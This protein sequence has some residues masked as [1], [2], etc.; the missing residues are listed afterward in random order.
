MATNSRPLEPTLR[1]LLH[2]ARTCAAAD[3]IIINKLPLRARLRGANWA[4]AEEAAWQPLSLT[5]TAHVDTAPAGATDALDYSLN[6]MDLAGAAEEVVGQDD[7]A[8]LAEIAEG[9]SEGAL[10]VTRTAMVRPE[11]VTVDLRQQAGAI[12]AEALG[13]RIRRPRTAGEPDRY[14][15]EDL[16]LSIVIGELEVERPLTQPIIVNLEVAVRYG[17]LDVGHLC[18][19]LQDVRDGLCLYARVIVTFTHSISPRVNHD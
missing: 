18:Q 13:V 5:L 7:W 15:I 12:H 17:A 4:A 1:R 6:Y 2:S 16:R 10:A 3:R 9:I 8:S 14:R 11:G 19:V